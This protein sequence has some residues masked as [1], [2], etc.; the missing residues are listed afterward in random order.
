MM[1]TGSILVGHPSAGSWVLYG[2]GCET[3]RLPAF[4][5]MTDG[6]VSGRS[7]SAY[8]SGFLPALY[9]GTLV[10]T[11]GSPIENLAPPPQIDE[12]E[13]RM[14]LDQVNDWN[15][16]HLEERADDTRLAARISNYELAFRMQMAAPELIDISKE[17]P[18]TREMYGIGKEPTDK[19]GRMCLLARRMVERNVRF[20]QLIS[21]DWDGHSECGK[22]HLDNARKIDKPIAALLADLK[23]RGMLE[24]T[25]VVSTGEFG[26][27]PVMQGNAGRDH[28][29]YGFSAW[30]AGGG[31]RGGEVI[32]ATDDLGF[33]AVQD[34]IHVHDLH[35]T[36]LALLGLD[37]TKL[38][39]LFQGREQ[40]LTDV[41]GKNEISRRLLQG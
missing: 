16:E 14:I 41:G 15:R 39:Y 40:R 33:R 30:M 22:N 2:L 11:E 37:H 5:V 31:V 4:M 20:V 24:S 27:T 23:Q 38:T 25:L 19:F 29:P 32:G 13:Q 6:G 3:D 8:Q 17:S 12:S 9:Q 10:R 26:R 18:G 34:K 1:Y 35:A 28:S 36:M 7:A 21:T